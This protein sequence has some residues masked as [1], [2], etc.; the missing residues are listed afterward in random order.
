MLF[1]RDNTVLSDIMQLMNGK[2]RPDGGSIFFEDAVYLQE[3]ARH[4]MESSIAFIG[5]DPIRTMLFKEM[6]YLDNLC[7]LLDQKKNGVRMSK[8]IVKS[9][10]REYEPVIGPEI[11]ETNIMNLKIQSLYDLIYYRIQLFHPKIVFCVQPFAGADMYLRRHLIEL[12]N[13][14]KKKGITV[15][16]LAVNIADSLVVADKLILLEKG[17]FSNEYLRPEFKLFRSEGITPQEL[18]K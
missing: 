2:L 7:F 11:H 10:V 6:S 4:A 13:Q 18:F 15:I 9:I 3:Q 12:I 1:D 8:R 14:L 5:E 16:F 17:R